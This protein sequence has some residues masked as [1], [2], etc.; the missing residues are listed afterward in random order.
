MGICTGSQSVRVCVCV[1][2]CVRHSNS[3]LSCILCTFFT[4]VSSCCMLYL[5]LTVGDPC[6]MMSKCSVVKDSQGTLVYAIFRT[7]LLYVYLRKIMCA[8]LRSVSIP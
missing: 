8:L 4:D 6:I 3:I 2:V 7:D 1:G 5:S